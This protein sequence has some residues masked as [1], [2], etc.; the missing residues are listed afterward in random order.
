MIG[1]LNIL[2]IVI[3][4][5]LLV[6][7]LFGILK[8][9][10]RELF[11][12]AFFIVAVVLSFLFYHDMGNMFVPHL[13]NRDVANFAGFITIFTLVLVIGAVVTYFIKKIFTLGP[14]KTI[15]IILGGVFGLLRGILISSVILFALLAFPVDNRLVLKSQL[16]PY[17]M[18]TIEVCLGFL[19]GEYKEKVKI[20][21][22][23]E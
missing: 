10:I 11:S 2:D 17:L 16:S 22:Y 7:I 8:G 13:K 1:A 5:I 12:L 14:L 9:F 6:S 20:Y 21:K 19:P 4:F 23:G 15:D 3:I 18:K